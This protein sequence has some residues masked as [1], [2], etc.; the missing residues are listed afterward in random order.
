V[1]KVKKF[2]IEKRKGIIFYSAVSLIFC[3]F[4]FLAFDQKIDTVMKLVYW[5]I[6]LIGETLRDLSLV[7]KAGNVFSYVLFIMICGMPMF[8]YA[9]WA[10]KR[11]K[12]GIGLAISAILS[13]ALFFTVYMFINPF[14][15]NGF[16]EPDTIW[17]DRLLGYF[18]QG[19]ALSLYALLLLGIFYYFMFALKERDEKSYFYIDVFFSLLGVAALSGIF[20]NELLHLLLRLDYSDGGVGAYLSVFILNSVPQAL[21]FVAIM[22]LKTAFKEISK[23]FYNKSNVIALKSASMFSKWVIFVSLTCLIIKDILQIMTGKYL[24]DITLDVT[25]PA[26][27]TI[28]ALMALIISSILIKCIEEHEENELT[29]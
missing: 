5:P 12:F 6:E 23:D 1:N 11:R 19:I 28:L 10:I 13:A 27:I 22:A 7:S 17:S 25:F 3:L 29:I 26:T 2:I 20:F 15:M 16:F 14:L 8:I 21:I 9:L 24:D 18:K 4:S